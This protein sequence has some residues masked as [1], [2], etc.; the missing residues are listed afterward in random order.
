MN[1][2]A[3]W[4]LLFASTLAV[5][6][7]PKIVPVPPPVDPNMPSV[8]LPKEVTGEPGDFIQ[9]A[10]T[11]NCVELKWF[12]VDK[13]LKVFPPSLLK[14][15]HT[16]IV[17]SV[18]PGQYALY[19]YGAKGDIPTDPAKCIITIQGPRPPPG[20]DPVPPPPGTFA[21]RVRQG[22][23]ADVAAGAGDAK[24]KKDYAD[25]Y[26][27]LLRFIDTYKTLR[28]L[29]QDLDGL[30]ERMI[31]AKMPKMRRVIGERL[32]A[33]LPREANVVIQE[34]LKQQITETFNAI[35]AAVEAAQ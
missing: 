29:H 6:D 30:N 13:N 3:T 7:P 12:T 16:A 34:R 8:V 4:L 9:V 17:S 19:S 25:N 15:T 5:G 33:D 21:E 28:D 35:I 31:G 1:Q 10:A 32:A 26:R 24:I 2:I 18:V 23:L 27:A 22:Y 20:P 14:S 11:T